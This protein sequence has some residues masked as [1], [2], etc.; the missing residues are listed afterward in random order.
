M[1]RILILLILLLTTSCA[2]NSFK[3]GQRFDEGRPSFYMFVAPSFS[4]PFEYEIDS[5]ELIFRE[6]EGIGCY[7]CTRK[8]EIYRVRLTSEHQ[9]NIRELLVATIGESIDEEQ[10]GRE[11]IVLD[12]TSWNVI[13]NYGFGPFLSYSTNNPGQSMYVL[14]DYLEKLLAN[15]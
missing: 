9:K 13:S 12:G 8:K 7:E 15:E 2:L 1:K 11:I 3:T 10:E 4:N 5:G 14:R 6:Y